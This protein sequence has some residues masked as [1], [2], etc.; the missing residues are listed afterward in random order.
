MIVR[1][2]IFFIAVSS[3][4]EHPW[5]A[6]ALQHAGALPVAWLSIFLLNEMYKN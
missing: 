6:E 5:G 3:V 1:I 2:S 4:G